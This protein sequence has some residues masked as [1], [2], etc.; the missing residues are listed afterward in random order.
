MRLVV[1]RV[2][3]ASVQLKETN[4][5]VSSIGSGVAV[6]WG[7][8]RSDTWEEA[9]FCINK[10][11]NTRLFPDDNSK[12]W[13]CSVTDLNYE[14]LVISQFTL[15]ATLKKGKIPDFHHAMERTFALDLYTRIVERI[16]Q[17]YK[18]EKIKT[19]FFG[20]PCNVSIENNGP[21]TILIDSSLR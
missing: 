19:G 13:K 5:T 10:L 3:K 7:I 11:L 21:C 17:L 15:L 9:E 14:I 12:D 8:D 1:Q 18:A 20:N 16:K 2:H 4:E 6:L